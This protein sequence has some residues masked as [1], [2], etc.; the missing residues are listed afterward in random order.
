MTPCVAVELAVAGGAAA[1]G[2]VT[3]TEAGLAAGT[4]ITGGIIMMSQDVIA[5]DSRGNAIPLRQ[6]ERLTGSPDGRWIQVRDASGNPTEM[7]IDGPHSP[8]THTD[9]RALQPYA[10]VPGRTN[11]DGTPWLPINQ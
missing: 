4:A 8:K 1:I 6:G 5:T 2:G 3:V 11:P 7:R 10:H 9:P